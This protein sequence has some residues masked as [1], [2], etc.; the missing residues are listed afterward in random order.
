[1][2]KYL[3]HESIKNLIIQSK[4]FKKPKSDQKSDIEKY[5]K[6]FM[7]ALEHL[8]YIIEPSNAT[9]INVF[10][11]DSSDGTQDIELSVLRALLNCK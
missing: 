4:T 6:R 10:R 8:K 5:N 11:L 9:L 1:M 2:N 3:S 7:E